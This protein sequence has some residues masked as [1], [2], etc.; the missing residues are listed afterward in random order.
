MIPLILAV[1]LSQAPVAWGQPSRV[2]E[3]PESAKIR[4]VIVAELAKPKAAPTVGRF[5]GT[6]YY[7]KDATGREFYGTDWPSL[8]DY[9]N[10][11]RAVVTYTTAPLF[12]RRGVTYASTACALP[13]R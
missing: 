1:C 2:H 8:W 3:L 11:P 5:D 7:L 10:A 13:G 12:A 6:F 9:V 4:D